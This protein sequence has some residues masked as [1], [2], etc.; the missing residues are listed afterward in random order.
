MAVKSL[1]AAAVLAGGLALGA[2]AA[3]A[4]ENIYSVTGDDNAYTGTFEYDPT[5][6]LTTANGN[7]FFTAS[8][9]TGAYAGIEDY[10][11]SP[12]TGSVDLFFDSGSL[13]YTIATTTPP[14]GSIIGGGTDVVTVSAAPEPGVWVLMIAGVAMIGAML[15]VSRKNDGL[16]TA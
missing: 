1:I 4:A 10:S 14:E 12:V 15:R 2:S 5:P 7:E 8:E 3:N 11:I 13:Y 16:A 9:G 6:F